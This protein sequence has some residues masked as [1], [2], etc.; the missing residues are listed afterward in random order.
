MK[1]LLLLCALL[2]KNGLKYKFSDLFGVEGMNYLKEIDPQHSQRIT[3]DVLLR[4][5]K[6][7]N[8]GIELVQEQIAKIARKDEDVK[9]LMTIPRIDYYSAMIIKKDIGEIKLF[10][11]HKELCRFAGLVSRLIS[12]VIRD[13][14]GI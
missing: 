13:G 2:E 3:L 4:Q 14:K 6:S 11:S 5:M 12:Q 8:K 9:R 1:D 10:P 7:V